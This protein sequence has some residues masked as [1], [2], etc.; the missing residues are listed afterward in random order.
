MKI[1]SARTA[2]FQPVSL[3][4]RR[5]ITA[6]QATKRYNCIPEL[7]LAVLPA[8][9]KALLTTGKSRKGACPSMILFA[10]HGAWLRVKPF[11]DFQA[12]LLSFICATAL[13]LLTFFLAA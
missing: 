10:Y 8:R 6:G 9:Y 12:L 5:G 7:K 2:A 1:G 3:R 11:L 4:K 13:S